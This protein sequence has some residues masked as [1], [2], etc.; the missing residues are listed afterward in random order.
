MEWAEMFEQVW[1]KKLVQVVWAIVLIAQHLTEIEWALTAPPLLFS[2]LLMKWSGSPSF[3][4][5]SA[6]PEVGPW[7]TF[8]V[9]SAERGERATTRVDVDDNNAAA[10]PNSFRKPWAPQNEKES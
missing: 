3:A 2:L 6:R 7:V 10:S 9:P 4:N 1:K 5:L 8:R